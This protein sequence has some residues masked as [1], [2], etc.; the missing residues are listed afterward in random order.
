MSVKPVWA[1]SSGAVQ[2]IRV[3]STVSWQTA[4]FNTRSVTLTENLYNW[5][6]A[7]SAK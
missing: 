5:V 6:T 7:G 3:T 4:A 2:E 1:D